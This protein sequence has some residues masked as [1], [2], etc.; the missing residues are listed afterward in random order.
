M[1]KKYLLNEV[2]HPKHLGILFCFVFY[3]NW[4]Y[5]P[6]CFHPS[7][8]I[9]L[10]SLLMT[11]WID[12]GYC[13][14]FF[15]TYVLPVSC[16]RSALNVHLTNNDINQYYY[17]WA[18]IS[19]IFKRTPWDSKKWFAEIQILYWL[20]FPNSTRTKMAWQECGTLSIQFTLNKKEA[21]NWVQ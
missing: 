10:N 12:L 19:I 9:G 21:L 1:L 20:C 4:M 13:L 8:S 5:L 2:C 11:L 17:H 6:K 15:L 14:L 3:I 18:Q 16:T 7:P